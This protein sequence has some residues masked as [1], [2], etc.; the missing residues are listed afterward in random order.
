[1]TNNQSP[2]IRQ[3]RPA[4]T[5]HVLPPVQRYAPACRTEV[6][7]D[8]DSRIAHPSSVPS[9]NPGIRNTE[10][11]IRIQPSINPP[12]H[13]SNN[14]SSGASSPDINPSIHKSNHPSAAPRKV[15]RNG[16]IARLPHPVRDMVNRMLRNN[17]PHSKISD[18]LTE[19]GV[20][21]TP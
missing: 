14:P 18:A 16:K 19:H 15:S 4:S 17:I 10:H 2:N 12:I 6:S 5:T 1:M 9:E 21:A 3:F 8:S 13:Q 7:N 20:T 11:A